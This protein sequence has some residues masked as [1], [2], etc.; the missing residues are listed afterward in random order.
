MLGDRVCVYVVVKHTDYWVRVFAS[1][2]CFGGW[3]TVGQTEG[4]PFSCL[5]RSVRGLGC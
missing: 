4:R 2:K 1:V 3:D 5:H